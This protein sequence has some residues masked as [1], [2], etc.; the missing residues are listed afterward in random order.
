MTKFKHCRLLLVLLF[1]CCITLG[2]E[3][4]TLNEITYKIDFIKNYADSNSKELDFFY[5]PHQTTALKSDAYDALSIASISEIDNFYAFKQSIYLN[6]ECRKIC[7][8]Q[9]S[10]YEGDMD[11]DG[12]FIEDE[13]MYYFRNRVLI[14]KI[15]KT[16]SSSEGGEWKVFIT[17]PN[18]KESYKSFEKDLKLI[19]TNTILKGE[20][21]YCDE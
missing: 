13:S 14:K 10:T 7:Y 19:I 16:R 12:F 20:D 5:S 8:A 17:Y 18:E 15:Q 1:N 11:D 3:E 9:S 4:K 2:Q 21:V 6:P